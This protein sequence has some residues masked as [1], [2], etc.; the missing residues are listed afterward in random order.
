MSNCSKGYIK[1]DSYTRKL[2]SGKKIKVKA[3]CIK[4]LSQS[5][6]KRIDIDKKIMDREKKM[7]SLA[8]EKFGTP[9]CKEGEILKEGYHRKDYKKS[10]GKKVSSSWVKPTCVKA[11]GS[12]KKRGSKGK[13]LF[14]LEKGTLSKYGY[15]DIKKLSKNERRSSLKIAINDMKPLSVRRKLIAVST[16]QKNTDPK[17]AQI[18]REDANWVKNTKE[19]KDAQMK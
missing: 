8:R 10:S 4:A 16:L 12:S 9:K 19:Y 15:H 3:N 5:G 13:K 18:L 6:L 1:R 11:K 2:S 17:V 7:H 14:R